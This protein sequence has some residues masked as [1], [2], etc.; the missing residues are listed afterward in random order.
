MINNSVVVLI[1]ALF[2]GLLVSDCT[3]RLVWPQEHGEEEDLEFQRKQLYIATNSIQ[4]VSLEICC[5]SSSF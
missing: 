5:V 3:P 1:V 4:V 2:G